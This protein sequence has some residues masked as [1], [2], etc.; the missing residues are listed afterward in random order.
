MRNVEEM[1]KAAIKRR[2]AEFE[3]LKPLQKRLHVAKEVVAML[4][5]DQFVARGG[6]GSVMLAL[7]KPH[8]TGA[9]P[10]GDLQDNMR[11]VEEMSKAA[12]KRRNAE[13]EALKPLQK[14]L[15]V[16]KEVVAMLDFDQFVARGGYGSVML[17]MSKT[18]ELLGTLTQEEIAQRNEAFLALPLNEQRKQVLTEALALIRS[19]RFTPG[20]DYGNW[21]RTKHK[22]QDLQ[23]MLVSGFECYGCAIAGIAASIAVLSDGFTVGMTHAKS[24]AVTVFGDECA[25]AIEA[26]Y[27]NWG[28]GNERISGQEFWK[29]SD[30]L[31]FRGSK[32]GLRMTAIF[33]YMLDNDGYLVIGKEKL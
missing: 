18:L 17:A 26:L 23:Q 11:N 16:A 9:I 28:F 32:A 5:F 15:H 10:R 4:D 24:K 21:N 33:Q 30:S 22:G 7:R 2:N 14:R 27:E 6:Y 20:S 19:E 25:Q 31:P 8:Q 29:L 12:I 3:A 13:F 1:S